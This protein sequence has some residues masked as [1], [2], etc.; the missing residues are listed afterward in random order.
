MGKQIVSIKRSIDSQVYEMV[1]SHAHRHSILNCM[2]DV[3]LIRVST[4]YD[5]NCRLEE[6]RD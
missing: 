5:S 4:Q 1:I 3:P 6:H 2:I